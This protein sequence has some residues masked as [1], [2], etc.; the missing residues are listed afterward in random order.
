MVRLLGVRLGHS[1]LGLGV[2][3]R[4]SEFRELWLWS[5]NSRV[6][7][8]YGLGF[9]CACSGWGVRVWVF[10]LVFGFSVWCEGQC[11]RGV[12]RR[13]FWSGHLGA[14]RFGC[15]FGL[16]CQG[17]DRALKLGCGVRVWGLGIACKGWG[18]RVEGPGQCVRV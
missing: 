11:V 9:G 15:R 7:N 17:Q 14:L 1:G 10:A 3:F 8:C 2:R 12:R 16:A 6:R 4:V 18:S 5:W 13:G